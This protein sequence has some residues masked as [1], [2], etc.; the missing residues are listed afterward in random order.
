MELNFGDWEGNNWNN[1]DQTAEASYWFNDFINQQCPNGESYADL[2][3]RIHR[4][5][6]SIQ[7]SN[8]TNIAIVTHGGPIR[9][10]LS[11]LNKIDPLKIFN[12]KINF[13]EVITLT[14]SKNNE[15]ELF[16]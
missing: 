11:I 9:A 16:K 6:K 10:F 12:Q 8:L 2:L 5:I 7:Q 3:T 13:G 14:I 15:Y 1:I 4:F